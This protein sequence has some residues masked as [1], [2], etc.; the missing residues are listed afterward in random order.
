VGV[1]A[2]SLMRWPFVVISFI[3]FFVASAR[4]QIVEA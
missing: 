3:H 1:G 2:D 4:A